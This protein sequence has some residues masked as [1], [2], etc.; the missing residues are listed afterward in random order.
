MR[1]DTIYIDNKGVGFEN[2]LK[3][4]EKAA[5][6]KG[7]NHAESLHLQLCAEEMLSLARSVT[8]EMCRRK[9]AYRAVSGSGSCDVFCR[10][11]GSGRLQI[12]QGVHSDP[13]FR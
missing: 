10:K 12:Q 4:T 8:G 2:A 5:A 9:K 6:Y 11:A 13:V 1:T 3:E 7:L